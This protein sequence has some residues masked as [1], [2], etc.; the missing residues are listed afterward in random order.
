M[1]AA[2]CFATA[3]RPQLSL[4]SSALLGALKAPVTHKS[5]GAA[6]RPREQSRRQGWEAHLRG[7]E[8]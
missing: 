5:R 6:I 3:A 4:R 7:A 8:K 2:T 1:L